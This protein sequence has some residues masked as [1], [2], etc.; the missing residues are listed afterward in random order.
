M[1]EF[2]PWL[3]VVGAVAI[4]VVKFGLHALGNRSH[5]RVMREL[6]PSGDD[7][8]ARLHRALNEFNPA[9]LGPYEARDLHARIAS[10][11]AGRVGAAG[12]DELVKAMDDAFRLI[13]DVGAG[14]SRLRRVARMVNASRS[15]EV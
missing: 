2:S 11:V 10:N 5:V 8:Q 6:N 14:R 3:F 9:H 15:A 12:H 13:G 4:L 7:P 1:T